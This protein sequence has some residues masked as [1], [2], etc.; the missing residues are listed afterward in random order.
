M[1][2]VITTLL[3][4]L[5][6]G[7]ALAHELTPTYPELRQSIY[8]D[9]LVTNITLFNRRE[10]INYYSIEVWDEEWNPIPFAAASKV[11]KINYL[12]RKNIEVFFKSADQ[13]RVRYICTR[14]RIIKGEETSVIAS[15][16]CS[17][18]K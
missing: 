3:W 10:D 9:V 1:R 18:I 6:S 4:A 17:K 13:E 5:T 15:N 14:S 16:I 8:D 2:F 12:E 11:I 7:L